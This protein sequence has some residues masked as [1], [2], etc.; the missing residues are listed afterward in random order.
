MNPFHDREHCVL[1]PLMT[2]SIPIKNGFIKNG[3]TT[4]G[5]TMNGLNLHEE[6]EIHSIFCPSV[7]KATRMSAIHPGHSLAN[8]GH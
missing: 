5:F 8:K 2:L 4:N 6:F 7:K 3:F 1:F